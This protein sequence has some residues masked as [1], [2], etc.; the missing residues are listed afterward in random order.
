[1]S[2]WGPT[3]SDEGIWPDLTRLSTSMSYL[4]SRTLTCRTPFFSPSPPGGMRNV[5]LTSGKD[6]GGIQNIWKSLVILVVDMTVE[7][8]SNW[9]NFYTLS[10]E[11]YSR[12][13]LQSD[14][15]FLASTHAQFNWEK[16]LPFLQWRVINLLL[17][18]VKKL[19]R[20]TA[21]FVISHISTI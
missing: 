4:L 3:S 21:C 15:S 1:M 8:K 17:C 10:Q 19:N 7:P 2:S 12:S 16:I 6:C 11:E 13:W 9:I 18:L 20:L 14:A 5:A